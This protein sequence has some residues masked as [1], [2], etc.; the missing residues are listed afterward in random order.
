VEK[1]TPSTN[2]STTTIT[3]ED[4]IPDSV[5]PNTK[6]PDAAIKT[7]KQTEFRQ[8][9][10]RLLNTDVQPD[11]VYEISSKFVLFSFN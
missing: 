3:A 2:V 9:F 7:Q 6:A 10:A 8:D 4:S 1:P 11:K 5:I